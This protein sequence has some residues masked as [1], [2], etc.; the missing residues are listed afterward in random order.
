V[1]RGPAVALVR[2][3]CGQRTELGEDHGEE[4]VARW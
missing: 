1:L 4:L 2:T 3:G